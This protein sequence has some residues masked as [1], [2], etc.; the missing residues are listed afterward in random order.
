M[1]I[2]SLVASDTIDMALE[3]AVF[4][5]F[6]ENKLFKGRNGAGIKS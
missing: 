3:I 4:K 6:G 1:A 2:F 5:D